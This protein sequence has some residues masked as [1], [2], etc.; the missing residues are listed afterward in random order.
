MAASLA[1][2]CGL[3]LVYSLFGKHGRQKAANFRQSTESHF[4][5]AKLEAERAERAKAKSERISSSFSKKLGFRHL[6][7]L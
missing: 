3:L 7:E 1:V 4:H 5:S 6:Q 2:L